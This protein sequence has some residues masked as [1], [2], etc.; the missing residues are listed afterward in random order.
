VYTTTPSSRRRSRPSRSPDAVSCAASA[1]KSDSKNTRSN[2]TPSRASVLRCPAITHARVLY[3]SSSASLSPASTRLS[4][5][6]ASSPRNV[7]SRVSESSG[8]SSSASP[9]LVLAAT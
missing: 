8:C 9:T 2:A 3:Q 6:S 7:S 4:S 1:R 5:S